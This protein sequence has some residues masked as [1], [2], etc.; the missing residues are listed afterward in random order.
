MATT[1]VGVY[2]D[3]ETVKKVVNRLLEIGCRGEE[4]EILEKDE[5]MITDALIGRGFD[6]D[7]ARSY[8]KAAG[9]GKAVVAASAPDEKADDAEAIMERYESAAVQGGNGS[10]RQR[11]EREE[12]VPEVEEKFSVG[13]RRV[14]RGGVR[15]TTSVSEKPV[16]KTVHLR[17]EEVEVDRQRVNRELSPEEAEEAFEEKTI[18]MTETGEEAE[19]SKE[20]R[21]VEEVSLEKRVEERDQKVRD[22]VRRTEV[23]VERLKPEARAKK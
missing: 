13:K 22:T 18:E 8:A 10:E 14:S 20:A 1:I 11:T 7:E 9:R 4:I 6:E 21:V 5:E 12:V 2:D 16:E 15:V 17:E 3:A 23:E 19:V